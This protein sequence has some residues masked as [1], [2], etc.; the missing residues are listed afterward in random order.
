MVLQKISIGNITGHI[1][2]EYLKEMENLYIQQ[3]K[4]IKDILKMVKK[5][6]KES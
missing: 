1:K 4:F 5:M 3:D 6:A 2:M